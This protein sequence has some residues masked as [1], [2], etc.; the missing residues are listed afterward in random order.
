MM[1]SEEFLF[2]RLLSSCLAFVQERQQQQQR[3][4]LNELE[5]Q[6]QGG[7][8]ADRPSGYSRVAAG[9]TRAGEWVVCKW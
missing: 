5:R 7:A 4:N 8:A 9:R 1:T 6:Q 3:N 2:C